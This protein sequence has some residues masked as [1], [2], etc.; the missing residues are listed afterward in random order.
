MAQ[1]T[2]PFNVLLPPA[3]VAQLAAL[4]DALHQSRGA[5]IRGLIRS[6][7]AMILKKVPTCATGGPCFVP[8]LHQVQTSQI[9]HED[10]ARGA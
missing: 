2:H 5:V 8:H 1:P 6:A 9:T 4:A 3:E 10:L 7:H